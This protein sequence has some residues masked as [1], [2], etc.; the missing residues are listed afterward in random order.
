MADETA[1]LALR[2]LLASQAQKHVQARAR[3][4]ADLAAEPDRLRQPDEFSCD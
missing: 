2:I 4:A 1:N 3:V